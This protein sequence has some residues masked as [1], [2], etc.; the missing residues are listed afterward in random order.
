MSVLLQPVLLIV[1]IVVPVAVEN[2]T[3]V[4]TPLDYYQTKHVQVSRPILISLYEKN[5]IVCLVNLE[6]KNALS[7]HSWRLN[8]LFGCNVTCFL[9][10]SVNFYCVALNKIKPLQLIEILLGIL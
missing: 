9:V 5:A 2:V 1:H 10:F 8:V 4:A 6:T 7:E 3:Y